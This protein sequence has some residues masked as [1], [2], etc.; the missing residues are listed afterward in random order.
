MCY[1][2]ESSLYAWV[3]ATFI[4]LYLFYRNKN[5]DR[6]NAAFIVTFSTIQ[7]LEAGIWWTQS[8]G[9]KN[10]T[11][12][13]LTKLVLL[14]LLAQPLVQTYMGSIY[15][16]SDTLKFLSYIFMGIFLWGLYR[17]GTA[18]P[19]EFYTSENSK[20]RLTWNDS[21]NSGVNQ[22]I[23]G[24]LGGN[25]ILLSI[26]VLLL[27]FIGISIPLVFAKDY[28]GLPLLIT[29]IMTALYSLSLKEG[30]FG[31][32]WCFYAVIYAVVA[33]FV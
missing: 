7:L 14:T 5:Y 2:L 19:G 8:N 33:I 27:Y 31:S 25:Y 21:K 9:E 30:A 10:P 23:A 11:N 1:D 15:T 12:Q 17:V 16:K 3:L 18:K 26:T 13:I 29:V 28:R 24:I 4:S 20:G 22:D 32:L 6:W